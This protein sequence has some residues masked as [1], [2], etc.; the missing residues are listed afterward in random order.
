MNA[1]GASVYCVSALG[2]MALPF[3]TRTPQTLDQLTA[4]IDE[5][6][7]QHLCELVACPGWK[8]VS[9]RDALC[10]IKDCGGLRHLLAQTRLLIAIA[11]E[12]RKDGA[13]AHL[14]DLAVIERKGKA[15]EGFLRPF[16]RRLCSPEAHAR[17]LV[18]IFTDM[19]AAWE[20]ITIDSCPLD[21]V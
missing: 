13:S 5:N 19:A 3:L 21:E 14:A 11:V 15:I 6:L 17:I 18:D 9:D 20:S 12:M 1:L 2:L 4:Q 10:F 16:I 8:H 7:H